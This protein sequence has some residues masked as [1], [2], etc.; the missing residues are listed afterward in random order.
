MLKRAAEGSRGSTGGLLGLGGALGGA[1]GGLGGLGGGGGLSSH[2]HGSSGGGGGGGGLEGQVDVSMKSSFSKAFGLGAGGADGGV[3]A[4]LPGG[5]LGGAAGVGGNA[6]AVY[7]QR[8][9]VLLAGL[10]AGFL[11]LLLLLRAGAASLS[12]AAA[13]GEAGGAGAGG[14]GGSHALGASGA[15]L[16]VFPDSF[17][18]A[19]I[20]DLDQRSKRE[21]R[22]AGK[23]WHSIYMTGTLRRAGGELALAGPGAAAGASAGGYSMA[24]DAPAEV[25]TGHNEAGRGCELSE[26]VHFGDALLTFDDRSGIMFEVKNPERSDTAAAAAAASAAAPF[27][28][29]RH[30]FAEGSGEVNDKGL[31]VEWATV[32]DGLLYVGSFGK[33]YTNSK[34]ETLHRNN[35]WVKTV[36]R[37][38]VVHSLDWT[39]NYERMRRALGY[40]QPGYLLHESVTWSPHHRKWFVLP[41]RMSKTQY[42]EDE[43]ERKGHNTIVVCSHDFSEIRSFTVGPRTPER[44]FASAKFLPG[45]RDSVLVVLKSEEFAATGVQKTFLAVY[46]MEGGGA[47]AGWRELMAETELPVEAKFEGIAVLSE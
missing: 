6:A 12:G 42:N 18:L 33:E 30:I 21:G 25:Q 31:K 39:E 10:A 4:L 23:L 35:L 36:S 13:F 46:G 37:E 47:D 28:V 3:G 44:G 34:G 1:F 20:A 19:V 7:A 32:K 22:D 9:C 26:L 43:D 45:S 8:R 24:W 40:E 15:R 5:I 14:S 29:P 2:A 17:R 27:I 41:R 11:A 16:D 38:G